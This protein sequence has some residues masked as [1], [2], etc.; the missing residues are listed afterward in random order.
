MTFLFQDD[1]PEFDIHKYGDHVINQIPS[2][3]DE[4]LFADCVKKEKWEICRHF[5]AA[6][7]L[8]S[9]LFIAET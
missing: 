9:C 1:R 7:Q 6:L 5:A 2:I 3:G 8:V 4:R